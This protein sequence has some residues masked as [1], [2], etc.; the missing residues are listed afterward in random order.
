MEVMNVAA[1]I[2][3]LATSFRERMLVRIFCSK[4]CGGV[5]LGWFE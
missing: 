4:A 1:A 2:R 5:R 3:H